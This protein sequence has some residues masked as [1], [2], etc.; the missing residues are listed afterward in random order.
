MS[1]NGQTDRPV[2]SELSVMLD[3]YSDEGD[4]DAIRKAYFGLAHG[5]PSTFA[6]QFSVL[7]TAHAQALKAYRRPDL[8]IQKAQVDVLIHIAPTSD[9]SIS[10]HPMHSCLTAHCALQ[11]Q[12]ADLPVLPSRADF[13]SWLR[14]QDAGSP[15]HQA[16]SSSTFAS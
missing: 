15:M 7:L 14:H 13:R 10:N 5:D 4:R 3:L 12:V 11:S 16:E 9:H 1:E 2:P 6:V 8:G